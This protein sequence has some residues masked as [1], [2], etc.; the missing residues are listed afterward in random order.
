MQQS[1]RLRRSP[2][3]FRAMTGITPE[4]FDWLLKQLKPLSDEAHAKRLSYK[5]RKR[6]IGAGRRFE[7]SLDDSFLMLLIYYR[8]YV[9]QEFIAFLFH[10]HNS[11]VS[12]HIGS[13]EPLLTRIFKIPE[14]KVHI[15]EDEIMEAFYDGTEQPINRPKYKQKKN[16]SGKKKRHTVKHQVV[17]VRKKKK[18]GPGKHKKRKVRIAGVSKAFSGKT[19]DKEMFDR[20]RTYVPPGVDEYGDTGYLGTR[21]IIPYKKPRGKELTKRKKQYN[22]SHSS[23]RVNVEHGIGKMKIWRISADKYRNALKKHTVMFKN[24]AGLQNLMYA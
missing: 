21:L 13:L 15:S 18:R 12:R 10:T 4:K 19:H 2:K 9:S 3:Q 14:R 17:T 1:T 7:S 16:Y 23:L 24:V 8:T 20:T 11:T 6:A 22:R 5:N